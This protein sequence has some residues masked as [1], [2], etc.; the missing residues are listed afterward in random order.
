[1]EKVKEVL[2][3]KNYICSTKFGEATLFF[4]VEEGATYLNI[5]L[6]VGK[7]NWATHKIMLTQE[8]EYDEFDL[9]SV[10][11]LLAQH[12]ATFERMEEA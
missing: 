9:E 3:G 4:T 8:S 12:G 2:I 6:P 1:M 10:Q 7:R 5:K 11:L